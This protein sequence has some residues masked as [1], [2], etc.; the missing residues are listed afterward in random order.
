M[1]FATE[2]LIPLQFLFTFRM[3]HTKF[4]IN[5]AKNASLV[6]RNVL[7]WR[8]VLPKVILEN[9]DYA[10]PSSTCCAACSS[11]SCKPMINDSGLLLEPRSGS[12]SSMLK[13]RNAIVKAASFSGF[14]KMKSI[15][16]TLAR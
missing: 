9:L 13:F 10:L 16:V 8:K 6:G 3:S 5:D 12:W 2:L 11:E 15:F 7:K 1:F 14:D 4:T